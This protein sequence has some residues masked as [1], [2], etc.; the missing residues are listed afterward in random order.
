MT[1]KNYPLHECAE[2]AEQLI[3]D[4]ADV[5]QKW[6]CGGCG[7]RVTA[8]SANA[9]TTMGHHEEKKDGSPCGHVTDMRVTGCNYMVIAAGNTKAA[10]TILKRDDE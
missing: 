8:N 5:Y 9:F 10:E 1:Y 3:R 4:G 7:E 6:T 2:R